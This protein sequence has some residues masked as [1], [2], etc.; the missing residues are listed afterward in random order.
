M[1]RR[2]LIQYGYG[3]ATR[4]IPELQEPRGS[5]VLRSLSSLPPRAVGDRL[6]ARCKD[7]LLDCFTIIHWPSILQW[8]ERAY[9]SDSLKDLPQSHAALLYAVMACGTLGDTQSDDCNFGNSSRAL[10]YSISGTPTNN[11]VTAGF[12]LTLYYWELD[13]T[14][15]AWTTLGFVVRLAQDLGLHRENAESVEEGHDN[16]RCLW[17]CIYVIDRSGLY[18]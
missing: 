17:W 4:K 12:L 3:L 1:V 18:L 5:S 2:N 14:S 10:L 15:T 11:Q 6:I 8:Y 16:S 7:C 13:S 9:Q